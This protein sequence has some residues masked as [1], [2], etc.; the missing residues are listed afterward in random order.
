M[1]VIILVLCFFIGFLNNANAI[2][3]Y[4]C[5]DRDGNSFFTDTPQ[6]GMECVSKESFETSSQSSSMINNNRIKPVTKATKATKASLVSHTFASEIA[7]RDIGTYVILGRNNE[8]IDMFYRLSKSGDQWVM[9]GKKPG[10]PWE[11]ISCDKGCD[12]SKA[13]SAEIIS[14]FPDTFMSKSDIACIKNIAQAFCRYNPKE[15]STKSDY[16]V[17]DL[18]TGNHIPIFIRRV[19]P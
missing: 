10:K 5:I 2:E 4:N 19:Y 18:I 1:R 17:V 8:P 12:Y 11:N 13:T 14:Y 6:D 16:V 7:E 9:E 15:D 3:M